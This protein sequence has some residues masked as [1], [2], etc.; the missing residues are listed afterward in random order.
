MLQHQGPT[1]LLV[2]QHHQE[3]DLLGK[4]SIGIT[5]SCAGMV[6]ENDE[7]MLAT[8]KSGEPRRQP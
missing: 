1:N 6:M 5:A 7:F 2:R 3:S 8:A 4:H